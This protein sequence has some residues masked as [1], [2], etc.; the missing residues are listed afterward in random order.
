LL[1]A[2]KLEAVGRLAGGVAHDFNNLLTVISGYADILLSSKGY[3]DA[4]RADMREIVKAGRRAQSLTDQLLAYSRKQIHT[5]QVI[6]LNAEVLQ[7]EAMLRRLIGEHITLRTELATDLG[8]I[9]ADPGQLQQVLM[10]LA[11]N[12]RDAMADGGTLTIA[13]SNVTIG[14]MPDPAR[15][16]LLAG[17]WVVLTVRDT[18]GG[19]YHETLSH[20]F[21]PFF[22]TKE[23]GKGTGL[24]LSTVYG[25]VAQSGGQVFVQSSPG[26]GATF[27]IFLPRVEAESVAQ[28]AAA[29]LQAGGPTQE[30]AQGKAPVPTDSRILL[31]EDEKVVRDLAR[32]ILTKAGYVVLEAGI[33]RVQAAA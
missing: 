14:S 15:P 23:K 22:T 31:V 13:T 24:G 18:G 2:R 11:L 21:E 27:E 30:P 33:A 17:Q 28:A 32:S 6:G 3:P 10:N 20:I 9:R 1:Q 26:Q 12:A 5:P 7:M 4:L 16:G 25:I 8:P 29:A 19:I